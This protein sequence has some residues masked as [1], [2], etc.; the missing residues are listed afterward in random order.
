MSKIWKYVATM[1]LLF[2]S[3]AAFAQDKTQ[4]YY[5]THE[6]EILPDA[7]AA[8]RDGNYDRAV[9]LCKWHYI[10]VGDSR[11]NAL[12]VKAEQCAKLTTEMNAFVS[13]GQLDLSKER[14]Q[15]ILALNPEDKIAKAVSLP[16]TG[17]INGHEWVDLGLSVKW[18]TCNVGAS[19][20][21]DYGSFFSW[22]E[23]RAKSKYSWENLRFRVSGDSFDN[24]TFSKY[25]T[26]SK[27]GPV[28]NK[29]HLDLSDDAARVNWGGSW[30]MPTSAELD[31]LK[32]KCTWTWTTQGGKTGY[33]VTSKTTGSSIFL[34]AAGF[35]LGERLYSED[36]SG[37][38]WSSSLD[39]SRPYDAYYLSFRLDFVGW[40]YN[41]RCFG[42]RVRP[43]TE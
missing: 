40:S 27:R 42:Y 21:S 6:S 9:E 5:N 23:T 36:S 31:E 24:V 26:E 35:R 4:A 17:V 37:S 34:P 12:R 3:L 15:A 22:G 39:S 10:I 38:Y 43:V 20:P 14:A 25:N 8:F 7:Q 33:K 1:V 16:T 11:A 28:D 19:S 13:S 30:R 29:T 2:V 18:A 41:Y 32:T